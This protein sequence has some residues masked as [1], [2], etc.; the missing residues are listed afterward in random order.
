MA[1]MLLQ[2]HVPQSRESR[3]FSST[4]TVRMALLSPKFSFENIWTSSK[5]SENGVSEHS[6]LLE[7]LYHNAALSK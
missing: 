7:S 3:V 5:S 1:N 6:L 2:P 4:K